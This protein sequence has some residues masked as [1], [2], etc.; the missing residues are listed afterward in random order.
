M[1]EEEE[2]SSEG[3]NIL[4]ENSELI[5]IK[6]LNLEKERKYWSKYIIKN[7]IY[8]P[9]KCPNCKKPNI[10]IGNNEKLLNPLRLVC[11]NYKCRYRCNLRKFS[12]LSCFPKIPG[13][14]FFKIMYKFIIEEK[15]AQKLKS[16]LEIEEKIKLNYVSLSK[17]LIFIRRCCAHYIKDYYRFNKLGKRAGGS[18]ISVD[19]SDFVDVEGEKLWILG[20]IN[21]KTNNIRLDV[22]K[23]RTEEDCKRFISNHIKENNTIITDGWPSYNF[24]NRDDSNYVHEV[25]RHG[26]NGNFGFGYHSTSIIEGAWG[27]LKSIIKRI[28]GYIPAD[29]FILFLREAEFRFILSKVTPKEKESKLIEMLSY[30]YDTVEYELYDNEELMDNNNYDF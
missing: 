21:N 27:T 11:N 7:Y 9:D 4:A 5:D 15:N 12:C 19:E 17:I 13:S 1:E 14:I 28:Y 3:E 8:L 23:T 30:L 16:F 22:Y 18:L 29:N 25:H 24:L 6:H 26:P 10:K 2:I 20:A